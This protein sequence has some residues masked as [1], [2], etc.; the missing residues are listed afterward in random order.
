[1]LICESRRISSDDVVDLTA[2]GKKK[3][4]KNDKKNEKDCCPD[5]DDEDCC[6]DPDD[7]DCCPDPDDEDCCPDP[8]DKKKFGKVLHFSHTH[9]EDS[10]HSEDH[11]HGDLVISGCACSC[12]ECDGGCGDAAVGKVISGLE[13]E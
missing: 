6:P 9:S 8:D 13:L 10:H 4:G 2:R 12:D 7:E 11:F 1:M 3:G 5:P